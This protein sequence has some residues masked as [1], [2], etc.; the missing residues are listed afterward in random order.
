MS[1]LVSKVC[2]EVEEHGPI[3]SVFWDGPGHL[4]LYYLDR[5]YSVHIWFDYIDQQPPWLRIAISFPNYECYLSSGSFL[6]SK[7]E[8]ERE[9]DKLCKEIYSL[10]N[11][12]YNK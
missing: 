12:K 4:S 5:D 10:L 7:K 3:D 1:D 9:T 11:V 6:Y 8:Y 2:E